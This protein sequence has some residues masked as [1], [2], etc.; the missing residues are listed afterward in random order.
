MQHAHQCP[1]RTELAHFTG[2]R[3]LAFRKVF[4]KS[5]VTSFMFCFGSRDPRVILM[6]PQTYLTFKC[7]VDTFSLLFIFFLHLIM[8][9]F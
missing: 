1:Q 2:P 3:L 8:A 5:A 9:K 7:Q 4:G 6:P